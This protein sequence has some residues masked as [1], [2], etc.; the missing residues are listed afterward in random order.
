[1][2]ENSDNAAKVLMRSGAYV[3]TSGV[4]DCGTILRFA[5]RLD[6]RGRECAAVRCSSLLASA[7]V[8]GK[9]RAKILC[10]TE[11]MSSSILF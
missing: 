9:A 4:R 10:A 2:F 8:W 11:G 6:L 3:I 1:M 5:K 7:G